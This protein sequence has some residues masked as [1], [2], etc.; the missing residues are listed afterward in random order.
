MADRQPECQHGQVVSGWTEDVQRDGS[1]S[2]KSMNTSSALVLPS[3]TLTL[4]FKG[5]PCYYR[6]TPSSYIDSEIEMRAPDQRFQ[7][8]SCQ[9]TEPT[10]H[11]KSEG[12]MSGIPDRPGQKRDL[13]LYSH[14]L[15]TFQ[16]GPQPWPRAAPS[17]QYL[18]Q[19]GFHYFG[20]E[21]TVECFLCHAKISEWDDG[22]DPLIKHHYKNSDCNFIRQK[23]SSELKILLSR[24]RLD[25]RSPQYSSSSLRL[26][27]FSSWQYSGTVTSYQLASA[28]FFY[29]GCGSRVECFSCGLVHEDWKSGDLPL[30]IHRQRSPKCPFITS[31]LTKERQKPLEPTPP[32][33]LPP[34]PSDYPASRIPDYADMTVRL[35][36]FKHLA[37]DFPVSAES[38]AE[39]GLFF[40]RKPG[41]M[42]CFSCGVIVRDWVD[43]D[44]PVEK[45]R[46]ANSNCHFLCEFFPTKFESHSKKEYACPQ[47]EGV[48]PSTLPEPEFNEEELE[49]MS[50]QHKAKSK[51][52][53]NSEQVAGELSALSLHDVMIK[54]AQPALVS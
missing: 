21:E 41:V 30:H 44:V 3:S 45:H 24:E 7:I 39:A 16:D 33:L 47:P 31:L 6:S 52:D 28:G 13:S 9:M 11:D 50:L 27:S 51:L 48:D 26:H 37:R 36:S 23:F 34:T 38:C 4:A 42:K 15:A 29:S 19:I 46:E 22:K 2:N 1:G 43:G 5:S 12:L 54:P 32:M 25:H 35:R 17:A 18:A 10:S 49:R 53:P 40:V 8:S 20:Y 14:R